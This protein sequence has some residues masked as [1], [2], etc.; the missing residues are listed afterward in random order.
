MISLASKGAASRD[1]TDTMDQDAQPG[2][3]GTVGDMAD[4]VGEARQ[5]ALHI[6]GAET[7]LSGSDDLHT[8][9]LRARD[10]ILLLVIVWIVLH[11]FSVDQEIGGLLAVVGVGAGLLTGLI[12][13]VSALNRVRYYEA[14]L[15]RERREIKDDP[16]HERE[17]IRI[18]Y[19]AKGFKE[20]L[21]EQIVDTLCADDDR[22]LKVMMEEELGLFLHQINHPVTVGLLSAGG[23]IAGTLALA[24]PASFMGENLLAGWMILGGAG[25]LA[26]LAL[27]DGIRSGRYFL[28]MARWLIIGGVSGGF[29]HLLAQLV[30][31]TR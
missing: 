13:G 4:H 27:I 12:A 5:R 1:R 25:L 30:A 9:I 29:V 6:L 23:A 7:H 26:T 14:E 3:T 20:P 18:L 31:G 22:L 8:A 28:P 19:A 15:D 2:T 16:E 10:T 24:L 21:L 11:N 17:E